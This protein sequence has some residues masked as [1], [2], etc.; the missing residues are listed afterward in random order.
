MSRKIKISN[1]DRQDIIEKFVS[2]LSTAKSNSSGKLT[3]DI[4]PPVQQ[5]R[6]KLLFTA[7]AMSKMNYL[8]Q[9]FDSEVAWHGV[10]KRTSDDK[11]E[12]IV[13]DIMIYPQNVTGSTVN[14]DQAEYQNWMMSLD[15]D[16]FN[17]VRFQGHSHVRMGTTASP[18][19]IEHQ[20]GILEMCDDSM[21]YVFVIANKQGDINAMI[22]DLKRNMYFEKKDV[23]V[24]QVPDGSSWSQFF[25]DTKN[26]V[27]T[28]TYYTATT[29]GA[30]SGYGTKAITSS[31]TVP[32]SMATVSNAQ[33]K[34]ASKSGGNGKVSRANYDPIWD[35]YYG[36]Y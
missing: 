23:D 35:E 29:Y 18:T 27:K 6:A 13:E 7:T 34:T 9:T 3:F 30:A 26:M 33:S 19:D 11:S 16:T 12:F 15:D 20:N 1:Q 24:D 21:F 5:E 14:T 2:W 17:N 36:M 4:V 32:P 28:K 22:Y 31:S 25:D 8:V 10:C